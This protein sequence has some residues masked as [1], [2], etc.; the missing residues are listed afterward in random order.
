MRLLSIIKNIFFIAIAF[1]YS[2]EKEEYPYEYSSY[3][4][5]WFRWGLCYCLYIVVNKDFTKVLC[6]CGITMGTHFFLKHQTNINFP[7]KDDRVQS[8]LLK[9]KY[10]YNV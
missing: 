6:S 2:K 1:W 9:Y 5:Q 10:S 4:T 8:P 3:N 7:I